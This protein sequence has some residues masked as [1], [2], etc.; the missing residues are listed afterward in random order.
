M[1]TN[2]LDGKVVVV[3]GASTGVGRATAIRMAQDG[4]TVVLL[5]R[6][7]V[8][9][10]E[11]AEVIGDRAVPIVTDVTSSNQVRAAFEQIAAQFGR[12]DVLVNS[13]GVT[14]VRMIEEAS[15]EDIAVSVNTNLLAPIYTTR[16]AIPLLKA[17]GGG[18][19]IN[20]SSE[21]TLDH[22]PLMTLY[23]TTKRGL[24]GFTEAMAKELRRDSIRV[25]LVILG[26]VGDTA[27]GENFGPGDLERAWPIWEAD[28]YLTRMSGTKLL[29]SATVADVLHNVVTRPP[30]LML[31]VIHVRPASS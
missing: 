25:T 14:R 15:D 7:K 31:D 3:S 8:L 9:L 12:V 1:T 16:S 30:E 2:I 21:I 13:A 5:A 20:I 11:V 26:A 18:D 29:L 6:R 28:G 4:A 10:D 17:A 24:N 23:A 22:M 27:F 19:I